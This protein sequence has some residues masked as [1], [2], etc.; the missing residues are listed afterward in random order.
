MR[1]KAW[2]DNLFLYLKLVMFTQYVI[3]NAV[4]SLNMNENIAHKNGSMML[5]I[6]N[7]KGWGWEHTSLSGAGA[8]CCC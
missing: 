1:G 6:R 4:D 7:K 8:I 2:C 3:G 5:P